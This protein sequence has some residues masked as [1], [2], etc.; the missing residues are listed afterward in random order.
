MLKAMTG[1]H[2][3]GWF[4][5]SGAKPKGGMQLEG[6]TEWRDSLSQWSVIGGKSQQIQNM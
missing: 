3:S 5:Y 2:I 1:H 4:L 6:I